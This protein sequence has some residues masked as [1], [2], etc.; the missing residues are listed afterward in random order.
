MRPM[1]ELVPKVLFEI[2][3]E[4]LL[5]HTLRLLASSGVERVCINLHH[6]GSKIREAAGDGSRF[7]VKVI[8]AEE[9][10]LLGSAGALH[11]FSDAL[12]GPFAVLYGDVFTD[13][14]I[15]LLGSFHSETG[16]VMTLALTHS[17]SPTRCGV[18]DVASHGQVTS[19]VEKPATAAPD[20]AVSA[21]V[22]VCDPRVLELIPD[23]FSDFGNDVIPALIAA[24]EPVFG[25]WTNAYF[26]DIGTP[27]GYR[28][29]GD[30]LLS[31]R[32]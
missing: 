4:P 6:L 15:R 20:A 18:V 12:D 24:G 23:G 25:M 29:A 8:Y 7:G 13:V 22:Y 14:D 32:S 31:R 19:F 2:G 5:F 17:E 10:D 16:A 9:P 27:E 1:T 3:G 21:G 11:N 30:S 28:L 26:Q